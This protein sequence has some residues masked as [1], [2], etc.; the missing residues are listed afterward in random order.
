MKEIPPKTA[1]TIW[2]SLSSL[3]SQVRAQDLANRHGSVDFWTPTDST[4]Y[5]CLAYGISQFLFVL[6]VADADE[7]VACNFV[8]PSI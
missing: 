8:L 6:R 2:K 7:L 4:G 3:L 1:R 5:P